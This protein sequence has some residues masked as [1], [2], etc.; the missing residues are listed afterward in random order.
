MSR[1]L[2]ADAA[3]HLH[4]PAGPPSEAPGTLVT[5]EQLAFSFLLDQSGLFLQGACLAAPTGTMLL[6]R[7][8]RPLLM[9]PPAGPQSPLNLV[10]VLAGAGEDRLPV[11]TAAQELIRLLPAS[12]PTAGSPQ[13]G[14]RTPQSRK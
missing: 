9:E 12:Q 11:S 3:A 10:R 14:T 5:Y 4:A 13:L 2:V 8:G 7:S 1:A 6:G